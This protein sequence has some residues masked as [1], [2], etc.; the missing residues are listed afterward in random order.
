MAARAD[1]KGYVSIAVSEHHASDDGYLPAP[2]TLAPPVAAV[3]T[4]TPIVIAAALLPLYEPVRLAGEMIILDHL[5]PGRTLFVFGLGYRP[6]EYELHGVAY[7]RR[8]HLA[9]ERLKALLEA[10]PGSSGTAKQRISPPP[11]STHRPMVAWGGATKAAA[12]RAGRNGVGFFAQTDRTGLRE[13]YREAARANGQDPAMCVLPSP[14]A[15]LSV[16][17]RRPRGWL[18]RSGQRCWP[19]PSHTGK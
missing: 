14:A 13:A 1:L 2:F 5:S 12:R 11:F 10:L 19:I 15:P 7:E 17:V 3:T 9:E 18:A 16:F 6:V 4:S 8:G